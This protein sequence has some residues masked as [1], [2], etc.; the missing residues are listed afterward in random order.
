MAPSQI[1]PDQGGLLQ[2]GKAKMAPS[3]IKPN[4]R[5]FLQ[6]SV[7]SFYIALPHLKNWHLQNSRNHKILFCLC[8]SIRRTCSVQ[9]PAFCVYEIHSALL[10]SVAT[11]WASVKHRPMRMLP[12]CHLCLLVAILSRYTPTRCHVFVWFCLADMFSCKQV[13]SHLRVPNG[14]QHPP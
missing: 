2:R 13:G 12:G 7:F 3:Q 10:H 6:G 9:I 1:K 14:V 11:V 5:W 8:L 4:I